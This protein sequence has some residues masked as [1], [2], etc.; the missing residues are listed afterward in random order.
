M[1]AVM[2]QMITDL[3][4]ILLLDKGL[5]TY[6]N[7]FTIK[8]QPPV[9]QEELDKRDNTSSMIGISDDVLRLAGDIED[10]IIKMKM[11]K[12][13]LSNSIT[14]QEVIELLQEYID[15]L[16]EQKEEEV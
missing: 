1:Q 16:V 11:T 5:D 3:I 9:T 7:K 15:G 14:N 12:S 6:I 8:M 10:P 4:N 2:C 13:L